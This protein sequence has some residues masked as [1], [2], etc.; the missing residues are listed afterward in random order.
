MP[1]NNARQIN[2]TMAKVTHDI[3]RKA[4]NAEL[5]DKKLSSWVLETILQTIEKDKWLKNMLPIYL[6][7]VLIKMVFYFG[8]NI[9]RIL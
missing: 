8:T 7:W 4:W 5:T 9:L 6:M 1:R 2:L 3:I